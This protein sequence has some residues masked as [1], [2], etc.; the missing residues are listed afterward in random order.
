MQASNHM[1]KTAA[2]SFLSPLVS[3]KPYS[4][5]KPGQVKERDYF[6]GATHERPNGSAVLNNFTRYETVY[7]QNV[8]Q[9]AQ[10]GTYRAPPKNANTMSKL[11]IIK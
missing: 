3:D 2:A 8:S 6:S 11:F 9:K 5:F 1:G 4:Q 10:P 7:K